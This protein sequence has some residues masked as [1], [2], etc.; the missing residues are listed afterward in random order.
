MED[1][2]MLNKLKTMYKEW[3]DVVDIL[4]LVVIGIT[5]YMLRDIAPGM[6]L[7]IGIVTGCIG[8]AMNTEG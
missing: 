4:A 3:K 1:K 7:G 6:A 5:I 8:F 2:V